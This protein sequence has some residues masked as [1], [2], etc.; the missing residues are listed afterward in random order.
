MIAKRL[1]D[2]IES[3][4]HGTESL[5]NKVEELKTSMSNI[6]ETVKRMQD[7]N[8]KVQ[9]GEKVDSATYSVIEM[10]DKVQHMIH[11]IDSMKNTLKPFEESGEEAPYKE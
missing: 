1:R 6:D 11:I 4:L 9:L 10:E 3:I 8:L 5:N 2:E 7:Y